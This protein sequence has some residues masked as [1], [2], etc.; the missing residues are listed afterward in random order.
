MAVLDDAAYHRVDVLRID[1]FQRHRAFGHPAAV[2]ELFGQLLEGC[3][4]DFYS[5]PSACS[6]TAWFCV[7]PK[8]SG[9]LGTARRGLVGM[10]TGAV[11]GL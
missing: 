2:I 11:Q 4:V 9:L 6:N 1:A 7:S 3:E 5:L 10:P 8:N